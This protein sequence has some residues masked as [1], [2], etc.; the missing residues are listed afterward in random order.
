MK[1]MKC[2]NEIWSEENESKIIEKKTMARKWYRIEEK[3]RRSW[4]KSS[5][6]IEENEAKRSN[7][8]NWKRIRL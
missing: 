5:E 4:R 3:Y 8:R 2:R 1:V 7:R 6:K